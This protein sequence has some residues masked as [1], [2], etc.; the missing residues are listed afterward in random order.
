MGNDTLDYSIWQWIGISVL[1]GF[2]GALSVSWYLGAMRS[3]RGKT[4]AQSAGSDRCVLLFQGAEL[5]SS[6]GCAENLVAEHAGD[7][8]WSRLRQGLIDRFPRFPPTPDHVSPTG[9]TVIEPKDSADPW[10]VLIEPLHDV[11]RVELMPRAHGS[12]KSPTPSFFDHSMT[13]ELGMLRDVT[14]GAPYPIWSIDAE[15]RVIWHNAAY[16]GLFS[17]A[18]GKE[19]DPDNP[20]FADALAGRE[21]GEAVRASIPL[22]NR[23]EPGWFDVTG[24]HRDGAQMVYAL[25]VASVVRAETAQRNFVQTLAKT[26]AQLSIG[27]AIFDR[28]MQ[29]AL[30]NPALIDL[31][32][33]PADFLSVRP[34][35]LTFFD[36]LRDGHVMPEPKDYGTWREQMSSMVAAATDGSY[37]ETWTLPSG[38]TYRVS[39]RPHPDGAVAFLFEDI[40]AEVSLTRRFR[41][42]LEMS[43]NI[44]DEFED[45]V[46]VF[47]ASG[48]LTVTNQA[49]R[50]L[51]NIDH[52]QVF[53]EITVI[54]AMRAWQEVGGVS[55]LWGELRD[56]VLGREDRTTWNAPLILA[57]GQSYLCTVHPVQNGATMLRFAQT[58]TL[59]HHF[60][61]GADRIAD[62]G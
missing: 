15:G 4:P 38:S 46:A 17:A 54:D 24:L 57:D 62:H 61:N 50:T 59:P 11:L 30:F 44:L 40:S 56:F 31:T 48:T 43:Q 23:E 25:D 3:D 60:T 1:C 12:I 29:L 41:A 27:L 19:P 32:S 7:T 36:R 53:A 9:S 13:L 16:A 5:S 51:W 20:L 58:Q 18:R 52:D 33:L 22:L 21:S 26:F 39:G 35:L 42:D 2:A 34:N 14:D 8:D 37:C 45:A 6:S 10:Q 47:T 55:P 49:Y 28:N